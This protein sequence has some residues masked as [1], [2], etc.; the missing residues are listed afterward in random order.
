VQNDPSYDKKRKIKEYSYKWLE[1]KL[2]PINPH[3]EQNAPKLKEKLRK[4]L[5]LRS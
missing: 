4:L 5:G 3:E 2:I 1:I